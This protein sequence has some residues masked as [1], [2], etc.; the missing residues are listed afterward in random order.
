[1][2]VLAWLMES[3]SSQCVSMSRFMACDAKVA[4]WSVTP[5]VSERQAML[6]IEGAKSEY[7]EEHRTEMQGRLD[8][9][10]LEIDSLKRKLKAAESKADAY[11]GAN[12]GECNGGEI[13]DSVTRRK[14]TEHSGLYCPCF[15]RRNG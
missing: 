12:Y 4:G 2:R 11:P 13:P 1:M 6:E 7:W 5:L 3:K 14:T 10:E 15:R 9:A 8:S